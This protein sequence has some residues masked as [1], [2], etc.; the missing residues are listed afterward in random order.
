M[1]IASKLS[2][3]A[4]VVALAVP[5]LTLGATNDLSRSAVKIMETTIWQPKIASLKGHQVYINAGK[6]F[7][8]YTGQEF[9]VV[10]INRRVRAPENGYFIG[11]RAD[12]VGVVRIT[13]LSDNFAMATVISGGGFRVGDTAVD[14]RNTW[15]TPPY[16][17]V[18]L[19]PYVLKVRGREVV[20][21]QGT[22]SHLRSGQVVYVTKPADEIIDPDTSQLLGFTYR[23]T[24]TIRLTDVHEG[25]AVGTLSDVREKVEEGDRISTSADI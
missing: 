4:L 9:T 25:F 2:V 14:T 8:A 11:Y 10:R 1:K 12:F 19:S 6:R 18:N 17:Y 16:E 15:R 13:K 22:Q 24:A 3:L 5:L 7:G 20:L 21:D 23:R